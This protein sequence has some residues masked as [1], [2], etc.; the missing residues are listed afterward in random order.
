MSRFSTAN[1]NVAA[2]NA[3]EPLRSSAPLRTPLYEPYV[4]WPHMVAPGDA[5]PHHD[6][7]PQY[8]FQPFNTPLHS[9]VP[10][11]PLHHNAEHSSNDHSCNTVH[12]DPHYNAHFDEQSM[13]QPSFVP[14]YS[15][16]SMSNVPYSAHQQQFVQL[17]HPSFNSNAY[18]FHH[19]SPTPPQQPQHHAHN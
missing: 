13:Q 16:H 5:S 1:P 10:S 18:A 6:P 8:N 4:P 2:P 12:N 9:N 17:P 19:Q 7:I 15:T 3:D 11:T 14:L